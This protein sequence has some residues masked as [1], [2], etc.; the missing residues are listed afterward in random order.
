MSGL[1]ASNSA[2][3]PAH[4]HQRQ[5][6]V[7][8]PRRPCAVAAVVGLEPAVHRQAAPVA[9][10]SSTCSGGFSWYCSAPTASRRCEWIPSAPITTWARSVTVAPPLPCPRMPVTRP[11]SMITSSTVNPF[12]HFGARFATPRRRRILSSTVRRGPY[13]LGSP[14]CRASRRSRTARDRTHR[15]RSPGSRSRGRG[16]A[17]PS[18][19]APRRRADG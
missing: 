10:S 5:V 1:F 17:I 11:S 7:G 4:D 15:W 16:R 8:R 14:P 13:D 3:R 2:I 18:G 19:A 12:A 9:C 6:V